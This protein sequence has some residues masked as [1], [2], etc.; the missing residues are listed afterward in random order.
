MW[1]LVIAFLVLI[2][3]ALLL[4]MVDS[5]PQ[6]HQ[7]SSSD[8]LPYERNRHFLSEHEKAFFEL[9]IGVAPRDVY[10]CP[11]VCF[12][13]VLEVRANSENYLGSLNKIKSKRIDYLLCDRD[14]LT[15]LV[16]VELDDSS[17][18]S[19]GR[20]VRDTFVDD[21]CRSAGLKILHFRGRQAFDPRGLQEAL[22]SAIAQARA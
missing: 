2:L 16:A 14:S 4:R 1:T 20:Q 12:G 8:S 11:Q 9:L 19:P 3:L 21:A 18:D 5:L 10:V 7:K 15:P 17:H 22:H 13:S 6:K